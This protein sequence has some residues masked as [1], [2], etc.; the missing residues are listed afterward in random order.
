MSKINDFIVKN[1]L[2]R[3]ALVFVLTYYFI[4]ISIDFFGELDNITT[5]AVAAYGILMGLEREIL[6]FFLQGTSEEADND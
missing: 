1:R 4:R 5:Q 2:I 3:R 6:R